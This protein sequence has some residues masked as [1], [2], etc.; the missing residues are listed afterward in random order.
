MARKGVAIG[1]RKLRFALPAQ[2]VDRRNHAHRALRKLLMQ[3]PKLCLPPDKVGRCAAQISRCRVGAAGALNALPEGGAKGGH[4]LPHLLLLQRG[5]T[6]GV[7]GPNIRVVV[8]QQLFQ[9]G[10][11]FGIRAIRDLHKID[12]GD[13]IDVDLMARLPTDVLIP[14]P[15]AVW[16]CKVVWRKADQQDFR[17]AQR[18]K[19]SVPPVLH[20]RDFVFIKKDMQ[21]L[22]REAPMIFQ[23]MISQ[24]RYPA[25]P[26]ACRDGMIICASI[27]DKDL[28]LCVFGGHCYYILLA[29]CWDS[30]C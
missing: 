10:R 11:I 8:A 7:P 17:A 18:S 25:H 29:A 12:P 4:P 1:N 27:R 13:I 2:A 26:G 28:I 19:D 23:N 22:S 16:A 21:R 3:A 6:F 14:L 15:P 5:R 30:F 20:I 9:M 24:G